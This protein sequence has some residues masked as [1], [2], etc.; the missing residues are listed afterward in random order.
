M[1]VIANESGSEVVFTVRRRLGMTDDQLKAG[2]DAVV[3]GLARLKRILGN[4]EAAC[5][6]A[7]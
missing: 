6:P 5:C 3:A 2:A 4:D 1:R 7:T